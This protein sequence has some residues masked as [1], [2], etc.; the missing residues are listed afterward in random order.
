M[1]SPLAIEIMLHHYYTPAL[2]A[3]KSS[4]ADEAMAGFVKLGLLKPREEEETEGDRAALDY[5]PSPYVIT[6]RG[7]AYVQALLDMPYPVPSWR[8]PGSDRV[9]F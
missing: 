5:A 9:I 3:R 1:T 8:L 7:R 6:E 4:P 2:W